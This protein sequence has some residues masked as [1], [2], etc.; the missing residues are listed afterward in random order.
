MEKLLDWLWQDLRFAVRS[1]NKD[2]RFTLLAVLALALGIGSVTVIFSAVY[3]VVLDTFPYAHYD[4]MVSFSI[5]PIGQASGNGREMLSI[6]EFLDYREQNHVFVDMEGGTGIPALHWLHDG[7]TTQWTDTMATSN[8]YQFLGVKPLLGRLITPD[9]TKPDAQPVFMMTYKVWTDQFQRDPHILGK[10]FDLNGTPYK[11]IAIMPPRFRPGWTDIFLAFPMDRELVANDPSLKNSYL[12]PLGMLKPG[13]TIPQ[14]AADLNVVAHRLAKIYPDNYPKQFRVTA[15]SFQERVTPMFTHILPPLLGAVLLLLL[16]ACTNV[17]NLLLSRAT[18]RDR[19]IAVRTSLGASRWRLIRQLL[20]ESLVLAALGCAAGCFFAYLGIK[21]LVPLIP[22]NSFPQESVIELNGIVLLAA[23]GLA[24]VATL[25]CGLVPAIHAVAGPLHPRLSGSGTGSAAGLRHGKLRAALVVAE[26]G[27]AVILV[28][29]AGLMLRTFFAMTHQNLGYDPRTVLTVSL[30]LP[31][32]QYQKP[33]ER[34][35]FFEE[36]ERRLHSMSGVLEVTEEG[37]GYSQ[38]TVTGGVS[39]SEPWQTAIAFTGAYQFQMYEQHLLQGRV[40]SA[41][42]LF[43]QRKVAVVNE[44]FARKFLPA[45]DWVG[46]EMDFPDYDDYVRSLANGKSDTSSQGEKKAQTK[47]AEKNYFQIVGVVSD[48]L[49][50]TQARANPQAYIPWTI[51]PESVQ[52]VDVHTAGDADRYSAAVTQ[53]VWAMNHDI[54]LGDSRSGTVGSQADTFA[55]YWYAEPEFEFVMVSTF[56][57]VGL[58]LVMI[59]VYSVMAYNVSLERREFGIRMAL[60]AQ[61]ADVLRLVL[62]RGSILMGCGIAAGIFG[63]WGATRLIRNQLW[64]VKPTD[65]W[66]FAGAVLVVMLTGGL[67]CYVPARRATRVDPLVALRYE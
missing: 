8:S 30:S 35:S 41:E 58:L 34:T 55:K 36:L 25:L 31:P 24:F 27:L 67:A 2:R 20:V 59:G 7:Q 64:H 38:V 10:L 60:G 56:G 28:I 17:S 43:A 45:G 3:G 6:P 23:M 16:I 39:H 54:H 32:G 49:A 12:W 48:V 15:R 19:E 44:D 51:L 29:G 62:R 26:I 46:K 42:D 52:E 22:Y 57:F 5:D 53:Q 33:A 14:A 18:A 9:D 37:F 63:A 13:A 61:R 11:L 50:P 65:P 47:P 21:E 40:Y 1:L 4:R 66:T